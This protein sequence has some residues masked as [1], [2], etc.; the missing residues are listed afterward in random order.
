MTKI[1]KTHDTLADTDFGQWNHER[2]GFPTR[3]LRIEEVESRTGY[4]KSAIYKKIK[5][6][7]LF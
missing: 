7:T 4:K 5:E 6:G 3:I 2:Q 1:H